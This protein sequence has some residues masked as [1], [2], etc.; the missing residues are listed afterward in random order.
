VG[1][2]TAWFLQER[3]VAVT[4]VDRVG[5]AAGSSWGNA[6]WLAP[7]KTIPLADPSVWRYAPRALLNPDAA[8]H[9]PPRFNPKLWAFLGRFALHGTSRVWDRTMAAL[10]PI[11]K[12]ALGAFD[13]VELSLDDAWTRDS[14]FVI[15]FRN[16]ADSKGFLHEI[17]GAGRHGLDVPLERLEDP[18]SFAPQLSERVQVAYR[19][20][21]QRFTEPG[22]YVM[23]LSRAVSKRGAVILGDSDVAEVMSSPNPAIRLTSGEIIPADA[24]VIA[25]GAWLPKLGR[26]HG[27]RTRVQAGRGYSFTVATEEPSQYPVYL[28]KQRIAC[29]PYQGRFRV[30]GT[31]E[32]CGP[33]EPLHPRRISAITNEARELLAGVDLEDRQDEWVGSRPVTPDGLPLAGATK[34]PGIYAAG[35]HGMWGFVLGPATGKALAT[36]ITTGTVP[37]EIKPFDPL[38]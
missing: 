37:N 23:S 38:R 26:P 10:A 4:V 7:G 9:I 27:I 16:N 5:P 32:F 21:G 24:V 14:P 30:A 8:L 6:G 36:L 33:D 13:E 1:L 25:T 17:A 34:S 29:T 19:L 35:G 20:D 12:V 3:G 2:S 11:D 15:G 18:Q 31:M 28:P 22:P